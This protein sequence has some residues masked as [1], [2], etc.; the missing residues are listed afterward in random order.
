MS[1][2]YC[3]RQASVLVAAC[4]LWLAVIAGCTKNAET[5]MGDLGELKGNVTYE[6]K[7]VVMGAVQ[8]FK[9]GGMICCAVI[10]KD[11]T[12]N[13]VLVPGEFQVA[14]VPMIEPRDAARWAKEGPPDVAGI[15]GGKFPM[16]KAPGGSDGKKFD[17][18]DRLPKLDAALAALSPADKTALEQV[19]ERFGNPEKSGLKV[20][21]IKGDNSHN[22]ELK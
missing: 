12:Y 18:Y 19:Q 17:P 22:F 20:T 21:V 5:D 10:Q 13:T 14:I 16:R 7:P 11:G 8:F 6:G 4:S 15:K 1:K 3:A 2:L 9:G